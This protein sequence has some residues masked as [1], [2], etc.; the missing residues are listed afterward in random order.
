MNVTFILGNGFDMQMGLK[1]SYGDFIK[2]YI[3]PNPDDNE[4]IKRFKAYLKKNKDKE[5]WSDA[6]KAFGLHLGEF[7][8]NNIAEYSERL[9]DFEAKMID[10]LEMQQDSLYFGRRSQIKDVFCDF[11]FNF[12]DELLANGKEEL[13][14]QEYD[15]STNF[16]FL[17]F[18]YTNVI[19]N[20]ID[21]CVLGSTAR[22]RG[23]EYS[24]KYDY[25][26][27]P[28]HIHGTLDTSIIMGVNDESQLNVSNN[29]TLTQQIK[30]QLIKSEM[31]RGLR[32]NRE[33]EA[34]KIINESDII[35]FYG[36][37]FGETDNIWWT[38]IRK[39]LSD[40]WNHKIVAFIRDKEAIYNKRLTWQELQ[41]QDVKRLEIAKKLGLD[42]DQSDS[43]LEQIYIVINTNK[44]ELKDIITEM[45]DNQ[46]DSEKEEALI[47][48]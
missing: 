31:N 19:D 12:P 4:N 32:I 23:S 9:Q 3:R 2:E 39:W 43:M 38:E 16:N 35:I 29:L 15:K 11:V 18:N 30:Y 21:C 14:L 27:K 6:E 5:M 46:I 26:K 10:Y 40:R 48:Q 36:V 7:S 44:L 17:T 22:R 37:S 41:Y 47:G 45:P 13:K 33:G 1:S 25:F 8:D 34:K 42:I 24:P 20:I 28:L